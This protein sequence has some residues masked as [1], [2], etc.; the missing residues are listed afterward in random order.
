MLFVLL[1]IYDL[2][3]FKKY[4]Q[5]KINAAMKSIVGKLRFFVN[6]ALP[7]SFLSFSFLAREA[8]IPRIQSNEKI[9]NPV[10]IAA[11]RPE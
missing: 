2:K 1:L 11:I 9:T 7:L 3:L 4:Q 8:K 5:Y 10:R 6:Q